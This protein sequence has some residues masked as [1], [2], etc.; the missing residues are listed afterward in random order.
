MRLQPIQIGPLDTHHDGGAGA[1]QH[2]LDALAKIGEQIAIES[3]VAIDHR[4]DLGNRLLIVDARVQADPQLGKVG[5]D[6]FVGD[7]GA[8]DVRA[9]VAHA[10]NGAQLLA[11][12]LGDS[13]HRVDRGAGFLHPVHQEVILTKIGQE[14]LAQQRHRGE[15]HHHQAREHGARQHGPVD[16]AG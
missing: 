6:H 9:E 13:P 7:F 14:L 3:R 15:R 8:A 10:G 5:A 16:E 2:F 11:G 1:G 4:L 12:A